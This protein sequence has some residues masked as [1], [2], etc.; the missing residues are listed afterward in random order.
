MMTGN[1]AP[2]PLV[3]NV[4]AWDGTSW[5]EIADIATARNRPG[6]TGANSTAAIV[7]GGYSPSIVANVEEWNAPDILVKTFTTS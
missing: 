1:T 6:S 3:A 5:T 4:E 2:G 7:A